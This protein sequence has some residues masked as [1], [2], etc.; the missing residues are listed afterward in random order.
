ML[1][2]GEDLALKCS[3]IGSPHPQIDWYKDDSRIV[4]GSGTQI[5]ETEI[6]DTTLVSTLVILSVTEADSGT[7]ECRVE[8]ESVTASIQYKVV[9]GAC[10][11]VGAVEG[12]IPLVL[13]LPLL[14]STALLSLV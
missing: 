3:A 13:L 4:V 1:A 6:D 2:A 7:Y 14:I 10:V 5:N 11:H 9:V 12:T 8:N